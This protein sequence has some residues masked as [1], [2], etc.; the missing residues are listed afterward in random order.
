M[1]Y[2][3]LQTNAIARLPGKAQSAPHLLA[4]VSQKAIGVFALL[5]GSVF[6]RTNV[7]VHLLIIQEMLA[8][9]GAASELPT[10]QPKFVLEEGLVLLQ[11]SAL[12]LLLTSEVTAKNRK[13]AVHNPRELSFRLLLA[14]N[15][16]I[17]NFFIRCRD[18][19]IANWKVRASLKK[20][21]I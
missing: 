14:T 10:T 7:F 2:V 21:R 16:S 12:V 6:L 15:H 18:Y 13:F 9:L 8:R 1:E 5:T 20:G 3:F 19:V 4:M 11:T 17:F